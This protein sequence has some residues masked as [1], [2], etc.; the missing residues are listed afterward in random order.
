MARIFPLGRLSLILT[1]IS[2]CEDGIRLWLDFET[3]LSP[4][5]A[6]T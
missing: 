5:R 1:L 4:L 6:E 2:R 3:L